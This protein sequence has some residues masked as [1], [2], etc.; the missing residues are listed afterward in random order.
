LLSHNHRDKGVVLHSIHLGGVTLIYEEKKHT[1][2]KLPNL[3]KFQKSLDFVL[4]RLKVYN[5]VSC[6]RGFSVEVWSVCDAVIWI[7]DRWR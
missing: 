1:R 6:K 3:L 5:T 2:K 4:T 7:A